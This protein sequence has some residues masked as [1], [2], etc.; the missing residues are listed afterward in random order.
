MKVPRS[1]SG[2]V[3]PLWIAAEGAVTLGLVLLLFVAHQLWWTNRQAQEGAVREVAAL[4][5]TWAHGGAESP[6]HAQAYAVLVIPRIHLRAPVAEGVGRAEVLDKGYVGHYPGTA[7]PGRPG[8]LALAG[9]RTTH[10]EPFRHLDRLKAGD[11]IRVETRDAVHTY[12]VDSTLPQTAPGDGGVLRPVPR[13][14][15]RPSYGYRERGH[16]LT[17]TT[18]TPAYTSTYRLVV[19]GKLRSVRLR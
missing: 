17:L 4:E 6:A 15:V 1:V 3:R 13:S 19:W 8:N 14:E 16:Y 18:C 5:R 10:G 2:R 11:E 9:H 7:Q 12:V